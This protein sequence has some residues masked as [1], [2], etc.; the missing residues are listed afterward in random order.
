MIWVPRLI[1]CRKFTTAKLHTRD[2]GFSRRRTKASLLIRTTG[3]S[4]LGIKGMNVA[5]FG[6]CYLGSHRF[7]SS[8][9]YSAFVTFFSEEVQRLGVTG[10]LEK[11][12]YNEDVNK[13][14]LTMLTRVMSGVYVS[15]VEH[16]RFL[17]EYIRRQPPSLHFPRRKSSP[18]PRYVLLNIYFI[19]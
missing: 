6:S 4:I 2:P 15:S 8:S 12:V 19:L 7:V 1:I 11:Y 16:F 5:P 10:S 17:P 3:C 14:G 18:K 9:A 13:E